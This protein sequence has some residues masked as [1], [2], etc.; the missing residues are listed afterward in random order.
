MKTNLMIV[1][2]GV[3]LLG[4]PLAR[5]QETPSQV[6]AEERQRQLLDTA[7]RQQKLNEVEQAL[8]EDGG[9]LDELII[10]NKLADFKI[11]LINNLEYQSNADFNGNSGDGSGVYTGGLEFG[12]KKEFNKHLLWDNYARITS[13]HYTSLDDA[14]YWGAFSRSFVRLRYN[15]LL[16]E[17][18]VGPEIYRYEG[19]HDGEEL[20]SS[21]T[22]SAGL[23]NY[24]SIGDF[25]LG[26]FYDYKFSQRWVSPGTSDR[27][28]NGI[29][30]GFNQQIYNNANI[31]AYY[32][33]RYSDYQN[34]DREDY[35]HTIGLAYVARMFD[36][37]NL[38][39]GGEFYDN[40]SNL[41]FAEYQGFTAGLNSTVTFNF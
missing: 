21:I 40:A 8:A 18:Y 13:T 9:K 33:F 3:F 11:G 27:M 38:R 1:G 41:D 20:S 7:V 30:I 4:I 24:H 29:L 14:D 15:R 28:E 19:W 36:C 12:I 16:P 26:L 32:H 17:F 34:V 2:C 22:A 39:V 23:Q 35:R 37:L 10:R 6:A 25:G 31:Q 5:A